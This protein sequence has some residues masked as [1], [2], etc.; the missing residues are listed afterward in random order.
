MSE[1]A[2]LHGRMR[3]EQFFTHAPHPRIAQ[4]ST[5]PPVKVHDQ[6]RPGFN[7]RLALWITN[8]VGT[9]WCAYVFTLIALIGAYG[10]VANSSTL[11]LVIG[12]ISQTFLQLVLLPIIIVGQNLQSAASDKRSED[13]YQ[14]AQAILN[15]CLQLQQHLEA[16]DKVLDDIISHLHSGSMQPA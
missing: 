7:S 14:D 16:Q 6:M 8:H 13:T 15:E 11:I 12:L 4:M 9:M 1:Q 2:P 5:S 3:V 10:I